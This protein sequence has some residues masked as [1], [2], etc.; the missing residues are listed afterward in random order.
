MFLIVTGPGFDFWKW[1]ATITN[2]K[3]VTVDNQNN[4]YGLL[5]CSLLGGTDKSISNSNK[6]LTSAPTGLHGLNVYVWQEQQSSSVGLREDFL[7]AV[8]ST[9]RTER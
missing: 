8:A 7:C 2:L 6:E 5:P 3:H 1:G 9:L 4:R